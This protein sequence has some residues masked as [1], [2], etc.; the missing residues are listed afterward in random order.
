MGLNKNFYSKIYLRSTILVYE[1]LAAHK[2][3]LC[4]VSERR[5]TKE[6]TQDF[7]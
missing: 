2:Q 4:V 5:M 3:N 7:W 6:N 1:Q